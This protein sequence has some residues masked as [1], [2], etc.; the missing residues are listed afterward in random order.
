[1]TTCWR[2]RPAVLVLL[3]ALAATGYGQWVEDSIDVGGAWVGSMAYNPLMD[4]VYGNCQYRDGIFFAIDCAT[5]RVVAS[6]PVDW[7]ME[8]AYDS[9]DHKLYLPFGFDAESLA[10]IDGRTHRRIKA[11]PLEW[12]RLCVWDGMRD[13][14]YV[15]CPERGV[16]AVFDCTQD[17]LICEIPV[18]RY[19]LK[20]FLNGRHRKLYVH[21]H[22]SETYSVVDLAT[23]TKV[24]TIPVQTSLG[25]ACYSRAG[26][27]FYCGAG[28]S[29]LVVD[30]GTNA[31]LSAIPLPIGCLAIDMVSVEAESLVM[32][33]L[34]GGGLDGVYAVSVATDSIIATHS[35]G[36]NPRY[37]A[38]SLASGLVYCSIGTARSVAVFSADGTRFVG[39]LAV[40]AGPFVITP[41]SRHRRVYVS[42]TSCDLVYVIRD[43]AG[44]IAEEPPGAGRPVRVRASV[45]AGRLRVEDAGLLL[46][47]SGRAVA[48][49]EKGEN[50]VR[51]LAPG[52]YFVRRQ[53]T[54][55][56]ARLVLVE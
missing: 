20:M 18:G 11:I 37:L 2:F 53:D 48:R 23:N 43:E 56:S 22:D 46:D 26:D 50:D 27:K 40:G 25:A 9:I 39:T 10:V 16:V 3:L 42:H 29:V 52:V 24:A 49:L 38:W 4:V 17:S 36:G 7:P 45:T 31:V 8:A 19:P 41:V 30:G 12:A 21:N 55:E 34:Y 33:S 15:S 28:S 32:V 13:R 54:G 44:G 5:N 35:T 14:L 51:R 6:W 1:M 47:V